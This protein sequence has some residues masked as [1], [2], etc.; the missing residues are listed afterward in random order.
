MSTAISPEFVALR[1]KVE[2]QSIEI[3]ELRGNVRQLD[4]IV[5]ATTRQSIWQLI[6]LVVSLCGAIVGGLAYQ[7]TMIDKR[8]EQI[9]KRIE[10]SEKNITDR[11]NDL[12]EEIRAQRK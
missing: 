5:G 1:E 6:V 11:F 12:K 3:A 2:A 8:I 7:T 10:L 4:R 9:E